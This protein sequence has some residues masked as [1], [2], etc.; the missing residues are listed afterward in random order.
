MRS[1][2]K[3]KLIYISLVVG[4]VRIQHLNKATHTKPE[5]KKYTKNYTNKKN[6]T[7]TLKHK[8]HWKKNWLKQ[9]VI[10]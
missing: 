5:K 1:K 7:D 2:I 10:S 4:L 6:K 8:E 9:L 3:N